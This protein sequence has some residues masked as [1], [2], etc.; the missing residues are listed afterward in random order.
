M[1][2]LNLKIAVIDDSEFDNKMFSRRLKQYTDEL[3]L[4]QDFN[5]DIQAYTAVNSFLNELDNTFDVVILDY[6]LDEGITGK[7]LISTIKF[8]SPSCKILI[9]SQARNVETALQTLRMGANEFIHKDDL[10]AM[11][12]ICF[13]VEEALRSKYSLH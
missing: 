7:E 3:A 13:F 2:T 12:R 11:P 10:Y 4:G 5:F 1:E 8:K 9:I 6:Y